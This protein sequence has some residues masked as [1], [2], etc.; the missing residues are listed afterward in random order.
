MTPTQH[1][2]RLRQMLAQVAPESRIETLG[3]SFEA[4]RSGSEGE[5]I[6][7]TALR[8]ITQ[9]KTINDEQRIALEAIVLPRFRPV[10]DIINDSF[11][12]P[13]SPWEHLGT[14]EPKR[15]IEPAIRSIGRIEV[16]NHPRIPYAGTG[17][18]VGRG[19]IMTNRHVAEIFVTGLGRHNLVFRPGQTA[20]IDFKQEVIPAEPRLLSLAAPVIVHPH[21]DMALLEVSGLPDNHPSLALSVAHPDDLWECDI[22]V[23]GYPAQDWRND[24]DLQ[25]RI[26]RGIYNVKRLQPGKLKARR[27]TESYGHN[28]S[29]VVHDSSTLGGNSGS[30]VINVAT[31][32]VL[33]LHFAGIYLDANFAVP[34]YE[35]ARDRRVV[36]AG[37]RFSG[38]V[39][40]TDEWLSA[41]RLADSEELAAPN[42]RKP[43]K[44]SIQPATPTKQPAPARSVAA[45]WTI[46][47]QVTV[48]VGA[49]SLQSGSSVI[50]PEWGAEGL[51]RRREA[52]L[53]VETL[54]QF[55]VDSL[56]ATAFSWRTALS[57]ALASNVAYESADAVRNTAVDRWGLQTCEFV[58]ANETQCFVA[59]SPDAALVAFRGTASIGDWLAD[60][61]VLTVSQHYGTV[62]RGFFQAFQDAA[63]A[64]QDVLARLAPRPIL[65]TGHSLGGALATIAAAEWHDE[66]PV[67]FVYT[68]GQPGVGKGDFQSFMAQNYA[69]TFHRFVNDD[70]VVPRVPPG[71][72]HV[73]RLYHF[74]EVGNL[75]GDT[76]CPA[77][78]LASPETPVL[79]G[80]QFARLQ[81]QL[82]TA[83]SRLLSSASTV[84]SA[85]PALELEGILPSLNEHSL[86]RYIRKILPHVK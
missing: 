39:A 59:A 50:L 6:G 23:I 80:S 79:S 49:P 10:V 60:L 74:D 20:A 26:F 66:I 7:A 37:V 33:A 68:F 25:N 48:T 2:R 63:A 67:S 78:T 36:D 73:G 32:E 46:P 77:A 85:A 21:W 19:L 76:E 82:R 35:L 3:T 86:D 29:A 11:S 5:E 14:S 56:T 61:N 28:V 81:T 34:A 31:G 70:D 9:N 8:K 27:E 52:A 30:A 42:D 24:L 15:R 72:R 12:I 51:F 41:W 1:L 58:D 53:P 69:G 57:L 65:L 13:P 55:S 4:M 44:P 43:P 75:Y 47:L 22:V 54:D 40:P 16:P 71:Y 83:R 45:T 84:E 64:L 62:H 18:V 38:T 17:F